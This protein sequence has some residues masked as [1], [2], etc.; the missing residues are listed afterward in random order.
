MLTLSKE[1]DQSTKTETKTKLDRLPKKTLADRD[2]HTSG[3]QRSDDTYLI[4]HCR[5]SKISTAER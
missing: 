5:P 2:G 1:H 4:K 3:V